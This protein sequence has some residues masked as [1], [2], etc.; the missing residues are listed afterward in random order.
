MEYIEVTNYD[1]LDN[2]SLRCNKCLNSRAH[3][4]IQ[5]H[6]KVTSFYRMVQLN[7]RS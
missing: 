2:I 5:Y 6:N 3:A 4:H 7:F 1:M